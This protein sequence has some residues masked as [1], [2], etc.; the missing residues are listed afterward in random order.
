MWCFVGVGEDDSSGA[1]ELFLL[2]FAGEGFGSSVSFSA[3]GFFAVI[4]D[5]DFGDGLGEGVERFLDV[6]AALWRL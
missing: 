1:D 6:D 5:F 2:F 4:L 3:A